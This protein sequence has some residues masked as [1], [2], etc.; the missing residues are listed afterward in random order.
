MEASEEQYKIIKSIKENNVIVDSVAG[1]GKTTT[2]IFIAKEYPEKNILLLTFNRKLSD[3]TKERL[4]NENIK[5]MDVFTYHGF[6]CKYYTETHDDK[7]ICE[8]LDKEC[9]IKLEYEIIII[10]EAQDINELYFKLIC[11]LL[12]DNSKDY[13]LCILGDKYQSIYEFNG[14]DNRYLTLGD[15]IFRM[16]EKEWKKLKLST[17]YRMTKQIANFMN[18]CILNEKRIISTKEGDKPEYYILNLYDLEDIVK[19]ILKEYK[20]EEIFILAPSVKGKKTNRN[21]PLTNIENFLV[22]EKINIYIPSSDDEKISEDITK[23]KL[24]FSSFHQSKGLERKIVICYGLDSSY[25]EFYGKNLSQEKCPNIIY[26]ALTRAKEKLIILQDIKKDILPFINTDNMDKCAKSYII[27][28]KITKSNNNRFKNR[29]TSVTDF[30]RFLSQE[31]MTKILDDYIEE[32]EI[33]KESKKIKIDNIVKF[34]SYGKEIK[35]SVSDINGTMIPMYYEIITKNKS[36]VLNILKRLA[37]NKDENIFNTEIYFVFNIDI[38][39]LKT[40]DVL[41]LANYYNSYMTKYLHKTKQIK[42]YNWITE[43]ELKKCVNRMNKLI[44]KKSR[45][46][47][48]YEIEVYKENYI[49]NKKLMGF[50]DCIDGNNIYEFKFVDE[51]KDEHKIQLC[52]YIYMFCLNKNIT[53]NEDL[54]KYNFFL[55]NIKNNN[56]IEFKTTYENISKMNEEIINYKLNGY[57]KITDEEFINKCITYNNQIYHKMKNTNDKITIKEALKIWLGD[58]FNE[59]DISFYNFMKKNKCYDIFFEWNK[60]G[61]FNGDSNVIDFSNDTIKCDFIKRIK[62][63]KYAKK[64]KKLIL[65]DENGKDVDIE[66]CVDKNIVYGESTNE[67]TTIIPSNSNENITLVIWC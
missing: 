2:N 29:N 64:I 59:D 52:T 55:Y 61:G 41:K 31:F 19:N 50:I 23:N 35:E 12:S 51:I 8:S 17:S 42:N 27:K 20:P 22:K 45:E 5:N 47:V 26:V 28:D 34:E 15:K 6:C 67:F 63:N 25:Y 3:E 4:R 56:L 30:V 36:S 24:V 16:N 18:E 58:K 53:T 57:V 32:V 11:K 38:N 49:E 33:N 7:G 66:K 14:A 46:K 60:G 13:N 1:S 10:D 62:L 37:E 43:E 21:T 65:V 9:K 44:K 39:K 54:A 48:D 40:D